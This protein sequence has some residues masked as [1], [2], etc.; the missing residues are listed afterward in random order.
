[1]LSHDVN[2]LVGF[3]YDR[4]R[5]GLPMPGVIEV[6]RTVSISEAAAQLMLLAE[7]SHDDEWEGQ[8]L[9]LPM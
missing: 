8:V 5:A 7:C 2:T 9:Y 4:T 3:A 1:M 6:P